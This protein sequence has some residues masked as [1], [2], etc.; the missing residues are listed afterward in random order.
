M[1]GRSGQALIE[2]ALALPCL[3]V[4]LAG[5]FVAGRAVSL[6]G[7]SESAAWVQTL[8]EGRRQPDIHEAVARSILPRGTGVTFRTERKRSVPILS[9]FLPAPEG[10][11]RCAVRI[12]KKWTE[13]GRIAVWPD[14]SA[15]R[16]IE[17]SVDCWDRPTPT[18]RKTRA[19]VRSYV[20][21]RSI[22]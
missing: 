14:L 2:A 5:L 21:T 4:L 18:G 17:A 12:E 6:A 10:R 20:L 9:S 13:A 8:R 3:L 19:L 11:T 1:R 22:R 16:W 7:S 15:T